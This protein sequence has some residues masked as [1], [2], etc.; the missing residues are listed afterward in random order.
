MEVCFLSFISETAVTH[1][2]HVSVT[3][4]LLLLAIW[5]VIF[6]WKLGLVWCNKMIYIQV[7]WKNYFVSNGL[8][9]LSYCCLPTLVTST[10]ELRISSVSQRRQSGS[11]HFLSIPF[12]AP[13]SLK[14]RSTVF[15]FPAETV[16][17][18]TISQGWE[19]SSDLVMYA[20][21]YTSSGWNKLTDGKLTIHLFQKNMYKI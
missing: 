15:S 2:V 13:Q 18:R 19:S 9:S 5:E 1:L 4:L 12:T 11:A 7:M 3:T 20:C 8:L 16:Y 10:R 21:S 17:L 6:A 14:S